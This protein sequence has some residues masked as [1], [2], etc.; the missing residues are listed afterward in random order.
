MAQAPSGGLATGK[1]DREMAG[2][3]HEEEEAEAAALV[4]W[5]RRRGSE[6]SLR[7]RRLPQ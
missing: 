1:S 4:L 2:A 7:A 5:W 6:A 3:G